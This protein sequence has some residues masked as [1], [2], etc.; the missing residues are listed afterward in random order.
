MLR[1]LLIFSALV[2]SGIGFARLMDKRP[3]ALLPVPVNQ[4]ETLR[5]PA[6]V[7]LIF[8]QFTGFYDLR[9]GGEKV[10][11]T[12]KENGDHVGSVSIDPSD[13]VV[14]LKVSCLPPPDAAGVRFFAKLVVEAEGEETFTHVFDAVGDIDDFVE[15]PF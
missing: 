5:V 7:C 8:S 1:T 11:L 14:F 15:L 6:K 3:A 4:A 12:R 2:V 9:I 13:P 10:T